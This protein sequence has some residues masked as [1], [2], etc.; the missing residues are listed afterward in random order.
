MKD[1]KLIATW[2]LLGACGW[3]RAPLGKF[4][5]WPELGKEL[6]GMK[7]RREKDWSAVV[8]MIANYVKRQTVP[9]RRKP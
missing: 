3:R 4:Q 7:H 8:E 1:G 5:S 9:P 6:P 2:V